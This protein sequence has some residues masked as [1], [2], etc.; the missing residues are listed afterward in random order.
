MS[1]NNTD[2]ES[3]LAEL[4]KVAKR[5]RRQIEA[6][7]TSGDPIQLSEEE[8]LKLAVGFL[9]VDDHMFEELPLPAS[10]AR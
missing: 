4:R 9:K 1:Q 8:V 6:A 5:L 7:Q 3:T 2:I 10:W